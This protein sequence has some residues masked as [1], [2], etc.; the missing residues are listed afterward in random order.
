MNLVLAKPWRLM[1]SAPKDCTIVMLLL[2]DDTEVEAHWACD[3]SGEDQPP[4]RG[5]FRDERAPYEEYSR[6]RQ[7]EKKIIGWR[8]KP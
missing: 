7:I 8:P 4:F 5:W 1:D 2:D 3:L 6:Y